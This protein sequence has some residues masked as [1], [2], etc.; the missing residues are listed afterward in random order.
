MK[1]IEAE[2]QRY[3]FRKFAN[4]PGNLSVKL[5]LMEKQMCDVMEIS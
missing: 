1:I 5:V 4:A 2:V 3:Q